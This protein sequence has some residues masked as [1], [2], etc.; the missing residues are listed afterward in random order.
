MTD[1][2]RVYTEHESLKPW[3][4]ETFGTYEW[5][6]FNVADS[7]IVVGLGMFFIH[8]AFLQDDEEVESDP[9]QKPANL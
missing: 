2:L 3:L 5:P 7:A 8:F 9:P 4:I 6:S 1:F